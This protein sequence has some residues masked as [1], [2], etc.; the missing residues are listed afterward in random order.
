MSSQSHHRLRALV[1]G[2]SGLTVQAMG[3][4]WGYGYSHSW[5]R[6]GVMEEQKQRKESKALPATAPSHPGC[7]FTG[8]ATQFQIDP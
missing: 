2:Y 7:Q 4:I 1:C 5:E 8:M 3:T 6:R